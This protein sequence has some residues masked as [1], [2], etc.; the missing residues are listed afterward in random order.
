MNTS[1]TE[2]LFVRGA[3]GE[4]VSQIVAIGQDFCKPDRC[5]YLHQP[6]SKRAV[7]E[8]SRRFLVC[9]RGSRVL[10]FAQTNTDIADGSPQK[11]IVHVEN[12]AVARDS[13]RRGVARALYVELASRCRGVTATIALGPVENTASVKFHTSLGFKKYSSGIG[14]AAGV[15]YSYFRCKATSGEIRRNAKKNTVDGKDDTKLKAALQRGGGA[16]RTGGG[17]RGNI[18]GRNL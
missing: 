14:T 17:L 8:V 3:V 2:E 11:N 7:S 1:K 4:D 9:C 15:T 18:L 10:G 16:D 13:Q 6:P 5:G 12:I